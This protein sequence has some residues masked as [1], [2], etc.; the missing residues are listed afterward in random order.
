M[1][2]DTKKPGNANDMFGDFG[3]TEDP[4]P[5]TEVDL[6][7]MDTPVQAKKPAPKA[8][9]PPASKTPR[10]NIWAEG[11]AP[12][13]AKA[14]VS[15]ITDHPKADAHKQTQGSTEPTPSQNALAEA[16]AAGV[17][18]F[19]KSQAES[20]EGPTGDT[21]SQ[22]SE[23]ELTGK[24][25]DLFAIDPETKNLVP[26]DDKAAG[27]IGRL[28]KTNEL[29]VG[30]VNQDNKSKA[31]R[32][33]YD[34]ETGCLVPDKDEKFDVTDPIVKPGLKQGGEN[35]APAATGTEKAGIVEA[36]AAWIGERIAKG[37]LLIAAAMTW[38]IKKAWD[39]MT[40]L[41]NQQPGKGQEAGQRMDQSQAGAGPGTPKEANPA[42]PGEL[43]NATGTLGAKALGQSVTNKQNDIRQSVHQN[44]D[45]VTSG[46][47]Q[48]LAGALSSLVKMTGSMQVGASPIDSKEAFD[49]AVART[50]PE[51]QAKINEM[52]AD[53]MTTIKSVPTDA[54]QS[55]SPVAIRLLNTED[56]LVAMTKL[57]DGLDEPTK[58]MT[59]QEKQMLSHA[60]I[61]GQTL[62]DTMAQSLT[63]AKKD[64]LAQTES[65]AQQIEASRRPTPKTAPNPNGLEPGMT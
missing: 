14:S 51:D 56:K 18:P 30:L 9:E 31:F 34:A 41:H 16:K 37:F 40:G 35:P 46:F 26:K 8:A 60:H 32:C 63:T 38:M 19:E 45:S 4:N 49:A 22:S 17:D 15:Q 61:K 6:P 1:S 57:R 48:K 27:Q 54:T 28:A 62:G 23:I 65:L 3:K 25:A 13:Q 53:T 7:E 20:T 10:R 33:I 47:K 29:E 42:K 21:A 55:I 11:G 58:G 2:D 5:P 24:H 44:I 50:K 43:V 12:Q 39:R 59:V 52:L 64:L 36:G